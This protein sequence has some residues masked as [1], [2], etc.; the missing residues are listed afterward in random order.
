MQGGRIALEQ[1]AR[2]SLA[3]GPGATDHQAARV[4]KHVTQSKLMLGDVLVEEGLMSAQEVQSIQ[5]RILLMIQ[6]AWKV[7]QAE[8]AHGEVAADAAQQRA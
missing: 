3:D 1:L 7:R 5:D 6:A 8:A 2:D 4:G